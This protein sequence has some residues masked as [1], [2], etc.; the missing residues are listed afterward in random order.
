MKPPGHE[1]HYAAVESDDILWNEVNFVFNR[2]D[3][4]LPVPVE[5]PA[6]YAA[7]RRNEAA[8]CCTGSQGDYIRGGRVVDSRTGD[9][10]GNGHEAEHCC[11]YE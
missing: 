2:P 4:E 10:G 7:S 6:L 9:D 3:P 11:D 8:V 1:C 5:S